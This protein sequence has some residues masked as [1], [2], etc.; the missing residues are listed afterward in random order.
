MFLIHKRIAFPLSTDS[1]TTAR[2]ENTL[3]LRSDL[4]EILYAWS[5]IV[6]N[7]N[8]SVSWA[9]K[10]QLLVDINNLN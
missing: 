4:Q 5:N 8:I 6:N 2:R 10:Y 3:L 9:L 7:E 1:Q